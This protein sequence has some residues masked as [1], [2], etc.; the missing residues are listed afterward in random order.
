LNKP[1]GVLVVGAGR[2]VQNNFLP[3]LRVLQPDFECVGVHSRTRETLDPVA[4]RWDVPP[5]YDLESLD[6]SRVHAVAISVPTVQN[7]VVL[8]KL[9]LL[10]PDV[11]IVVDTPVAWTPRELAACSRVI[12][13]FPRVFVTEDY[14]NFPS[15]SL[16]RKA[17]GEG[18]IGKLRSVTLNGTGYL[19]H[20]LALIR[21]MNGFGRAM[22]TWRGFGKGLT[23]FTGYR[24]AEGYRACVIGPYRASYGQGI[25]VE[26]STGFI[27][28]Y[29]TDSKFGS[30]AKP[31]FILEPLVPGRSA[32]FALTGTSGRYVTNTPEME[33]MLEMPFEDKS[34]LNLQRG[35]G[36][37]RVFQSLLNPADLNNHYGF[38][39]AVYDSFASR[40]AQRGILPIDPFALFGS[41]VIRAGSP[42]LKRLL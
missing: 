12:G 39:N 18:L 29:A 35:A 17:V 32:G 34:D 19:Y 21:S 26:G 22:Q 7:A 25:L 11:T 24:F 10:A 2:R 3:A 20:G 42:L 28:D 16:I 27:S 36:L 14:M 37:M 8:S 38:S 5:I 1:L 9:A 31:A 4:R 30:S 41:D 6:F 40:A 15:F 23:T 33:A 13:K